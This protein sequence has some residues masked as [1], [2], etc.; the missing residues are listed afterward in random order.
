MTSTDSL[1]K[2]YFSKLTSNIIKF[3]LGFVTIGIIPR[4]L[5]P[6]SYGSF[7]FLTDFFLKTV[8]FL[9]FGVPAA[10][11]TKLSS[12]Q[13]DRKI[14]KFY[15]YFISIL[16]FLIFSFS[17]IAIFLE[18]NNKIWPQQKSVF[19]LFATL[20][21]VLHFLSEFFRSTN[22]AFGYTY[23]NEKRFVIQAILTTSLILILNAFNVI[24]LYSIFFVHYFAFFFV[25]ISGWKI[26]N[27]NN[28]NLFK[29]L[30]LQTDR[31]KKYIKEFY[32]FSHPLFINGLVVYIVAIFD[33]WLLQFYYGSYEQGYYSLGLRISSVIFLFTSA[34]PNLFVREMS[35]ANKDKNTNK[36]RKL[37]LNYV[38]LFFCI[39]SFFAVFISYNSSI[40]VSII[41]GDEYQNASMV[42]SIMVFYSVH[43]TYGQ[44]NGAIFLGT[45]KTNVIRNIGV[46]TGLLGMILSLY[47]IT[48]FGF[49]MAAL[50]L[51]IKMV[52]VQFIAVNI[53]LWKIMK[54]LNLKF[55]KFFTHQFFIIGLFYLFAFISSNLI[56]LII[57]NIY[58]SF[59][60]QGLL[61]TILS[62]FFIYLFPIIIF[63]KKDDIKKFISNIININK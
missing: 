27:K 28:I 46:I 14:I 44:L 48:S 60:F 62:L 16:V 18:Y 52:V 25:I 15:I 24:N 30:S 1:N 49:G 20:F 40:I 36:M 7:N 5:G 63:M 38:P 39:V 55:V 43:Q 58:I 29:N 10:Y 6:I 34:M 19:V 23:E 47:L 54:I 53:Y 22:D 37:F 31:I 33:R 50:G 13:S 4:A 8:K 42:V 56:S 3:L 32:L 61:Y 26:L 45:E 59:L 35:L 2:R 9:K 17:T 12:N 57:K 51:S 21:A 41:G 11:F